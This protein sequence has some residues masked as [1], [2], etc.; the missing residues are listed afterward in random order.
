MN[1][2]GFFVQEIT[3]PSQFWQGKPEK[4]ITLR[5]VM[6]RSLPEVRD[7]KSQ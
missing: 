2:Y 4:L 7:S 5:L 3:H 6:E 1:D